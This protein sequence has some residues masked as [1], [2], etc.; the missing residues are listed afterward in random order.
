MVI[1]KIVSDIIKDVADKNGISFDEAKDAVFYQ[2]KFVIDTIQETDIN[3]IETFKSI[4]LLKFGV[5]YP[6][7]KVYNIIK[8]KR[9]Q[10]DGRHNEE[11]LSE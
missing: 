7:W 6:N 2:F 8:A 11:L 1:Q 5:F 10:Q 9:K 4:R 3:D